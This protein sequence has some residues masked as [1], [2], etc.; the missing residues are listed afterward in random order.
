MSKLKT[1]GFVALVAFR[2]KGGWLR[3]VVI[4]N[5]S[6]KMPSGQERLDSSRRIEDT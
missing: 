1:I 6:I 2:I 3:W 5:S 4:S